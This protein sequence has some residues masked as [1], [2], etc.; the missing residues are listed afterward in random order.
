MAVNDQGF[1]QRPAPPGL[2]V[3]ALKLGLGHAGVVFQFHGADG[4]AA[5]HVAHQADEQGDAANA[6]IASGQSLELGADIEILQLHAN[7]HLA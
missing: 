2:G 7:R 5:G 4:L 3:D 1:F 6:M